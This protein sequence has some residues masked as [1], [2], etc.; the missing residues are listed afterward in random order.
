[1]K[2]IKLIT[3]A[4]FIYFLLNT[5]VSYVSI[6]IPMGYARF[7]YQKGV[8]YKT[9]KYIEENIPEGSKISYDAFVAVPPD[10]EMTACL[11]WDKCA[12]DIEEFQPDFVL[13]NE[14]YTFNGEY[15]PTVRLIN[16]VNENQFVL[17][18]TIET[19]SV[20]KKSDN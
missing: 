15:A 16:Y 3:S 6:S 2:A 12:E 5:L 1:M 18:D 8:T 7:M 10:K 14:N 4:V 9:Y 19:V 11:F 13:F 20:W 17:I